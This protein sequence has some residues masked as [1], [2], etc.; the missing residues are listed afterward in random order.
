[1]GI[2]KL[3]YNQRSDGTNLLNS[4]ESCKLIVKHSVMKIT[5]ITLK[6]KLTNNLNSSV[7]NYFITFYYY[8]CSCDYFLNFICKVEIIL[9]SYYISS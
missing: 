1:M 9:A 3:T 5:I 4:E 7:S 8:L 6:T 2:K